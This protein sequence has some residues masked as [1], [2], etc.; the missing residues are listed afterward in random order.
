MFLLCVWQIGLSKNWAYPHSPICGY[1]H[2]TCPDVPKAG[3]LDGHPTWKRTAMVVRHSKITKK[4]LAPSTRQYPLV[5]IH[6]YNQI[7]QWT[8]MN[9]Q[10]KP[11]IC[12]GCPTDVWL[13]YRVY[14]KWVLPQRTVRIPGLRSTAAQ[15]SRILFQQSKAGKETNLPI[16]LS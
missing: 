1:T 6:I 13:P 16:S 9:W 14:P 7:W 10:S 3:C 2:G 15:K 11:A 5:Y 12:R 8:T 4:Y